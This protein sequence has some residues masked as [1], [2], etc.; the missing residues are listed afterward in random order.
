MTSA[1]FTLANS[2]LLKIERELIFKSQQ[3]GE[4][5]ESCGL[6]SE[7]RLRLPSRKKHQT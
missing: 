6:E 3:G 2:L 5:F 4:F 1:S 7:I